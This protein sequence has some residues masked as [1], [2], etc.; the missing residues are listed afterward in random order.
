LLLYRLARDPA[1]IQKQQQQRVEF[2]RIVIT[3]NNSAGGFTVSNSRMLAW[4]QVDVFAERRYEGNP[5]AIFADGTGLTTEQMQAIARETN[6]SETTFILPATPEEELRDGVRVRIFTVEE[7]LPFAGHPTLGTSSWIR[8][9]LPHFSGADE[10]KLK[11]N[12]GTIPV[13]F[14]ANKEGEEGL[15]GEM[16]QRD[17]QFGA[18]LDRAL[19]APL[20]G[21]EVEDLHATLQPQI[22]ST[23]LPICILPLA[24][25]EAL[26]RLRVDHAVMKPLMAEHGGKFV[27]AILPAG[28]GVWRARMPFNGTDDPATGSAAGCCISYLVKHGV[29]ASGEQAVIHQGI[30]VHRPSQLHVRASG[31][32]DDVND[33]YVAG[34]TVFVATGRFTHP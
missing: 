3:C 1:C 26:Q 19:L 16:K 24:S 28:D 15:F 12:A 10:V 14:R 8:E 32:G 31:H 7:E 5:L 9:N 21:L 33:V 6:L 22:V 4:A 30:E 25:F 23:G 17:P 2:E 13:R 27:Y 34:R 29:V 11:L 20:C 18:L